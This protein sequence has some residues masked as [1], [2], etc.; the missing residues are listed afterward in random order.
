MKK[1]SVKKYKGHLVKK[2]GNPWYSYYNDVKTSHIIDANDYR[3][4]SEYCDLSK[5]DKS[6]FMSK[7][8]NLNGSRSPKYNDDQYL[9]WYSEFINRTGRMPLLKDYFNFESDIA[10]Y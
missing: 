7:I 9:A 1:K 4:L 2:E 6:V 5:K 8:L 10:N 3:F